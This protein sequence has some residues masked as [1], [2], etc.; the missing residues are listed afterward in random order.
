MFEQPFHTKL[1]HFELSIGY[2]YIGLVG[3][4]EFFCNTWQKDKSNMKLI[5][6]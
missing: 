5:Y 3:Y 4:V 2:F 6:F 1:R